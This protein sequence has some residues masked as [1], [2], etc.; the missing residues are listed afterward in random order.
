MALTNPF[1]FRTMRISLANKC[2][3]LFGLAVILILSAAL[4]VVW[5]RMQVLV[6]EGQEETARKLAEAWLSGLLQ[7]DD[8][9]WED[10]PPE[11][12]WTDRNQTLLLVE[13]EEFQ[14]A[15]QRMPF[16]A[17][18]ISVFQTRKERLELSYSEEDQRGESWFYFARAI[19][20]SDLSGLR[21]GSEA[22]FGPTVAVPLVTDPLEKVLVIRLRANITSRQL[23]L[24]RIY[25]VA[26]GMLAGLLAIGVFWFITTKLVLSPV[27]VLRDTAKKVSEGDLNTRANVNTGDEFEQLSEVFNQ[28]L[29]NLKSNQD[30]LRGI[31]KSL[32]LKLGELAETNVNLFTAN[33]IKG[34]FLA[35]VSHELRTPLNSIIGFAE[36]LEETLK[37][38]TGPV[39]EKRKR[40]AANIITSSR[41][42]LDLINDL[43]DLTKIEA[44]RIDVRVAPMSVEDVC[45]GLIN[46][47]RPVADKRNV[48]LRLK[49]EPNIPPVQ[50]D[51]TKFQQVIF[52]FLANAA[53]FTPPGGVVTLSAILL[54]TEPSR[55]LAVSVTDTGPGIPPD[56]HERIFEKFTQLDSTVTKEYGGTGL[57]LTISRELSHLL[58]G[59]I[60]LE[61]DVGKGATFTLVIPL[62]LESRSAPLM[63]DLTKPAATVRI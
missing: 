13:K 8:R 9:W 6:R 20:R 19:R 58:Q 25:M 5:V 4:S 54:G 51:A 15:E 60:L 22:G 38:R 50:T 24:N 23:T 53:K 30:Q 28:M 16:L 10:Q 48:E 49:V 29:E 43:L 37:D 33:K 46:L 56:K 47:I 11:R 18:A 21:G 42:L 36:V 32:D 61:S 44:G 57:G 52:N 27:R 17:H 35:N 3:I 62:I 26:A 34:E 1:R 55:K 31:N 12:Q 45:E 7:A 40:Y 63:P 2:Q 39:D 41:R 59:E 14:D